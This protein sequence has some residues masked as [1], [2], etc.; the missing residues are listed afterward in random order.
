MVKRKLEDKEREIS[1]KLED[2]QFNIEKVKGFY[3]NDW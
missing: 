1:L 2:V 3:S